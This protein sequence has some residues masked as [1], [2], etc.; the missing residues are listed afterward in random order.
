MKKTPVTQ[1]RDTKLEA[2]RTAWPAVLPGLPHCQAC[3]GCT[4]CWACTACR[5][6][7]ACWAC[8]ACWAYTNGLACR[9][10]AL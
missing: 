10:R 7:T 4:A 8:I 3:R 1:S 2:C 6:C 9:N 5:A